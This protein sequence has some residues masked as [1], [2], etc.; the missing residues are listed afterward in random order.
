MIPGITINMG[1]RDW[2]VPPLSLSQLLSFLPRVQ[3]L[4][5]AGQVV[6]L[7]PEQLG[8]L[9]EIITA[10]MQRNYPEITK[11]QVADLLDLGNAR[12]VLA[13][14]LSTP[15]ADAAVSVAGSSKVQI[16]NGNTQ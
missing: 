8:M 4:T 1:D 9:V 13:A 15:A 12:T 11:E 7:G 2:L 5:A 14:T 6:G 10:A 3:E 16:G